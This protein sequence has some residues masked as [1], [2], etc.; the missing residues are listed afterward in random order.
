MRAFNHKIS[1]ASLANMRFKH[2]QNLNE[3]VA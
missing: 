1:E 2:T 3:E